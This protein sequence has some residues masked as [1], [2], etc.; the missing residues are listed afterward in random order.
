MGPV[1]ANGKPSGWLVQPE[2]VAELV[3]MALGWLLILELCSHEKTVS[4][5]QTL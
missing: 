1:V 5:P 4:C 2:R 3:E